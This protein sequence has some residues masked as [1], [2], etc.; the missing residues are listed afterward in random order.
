[1]GGWRGGVGR[2][3][4]FLVP[5]GSLTQ[6]GTPSLL[7]ATRQLWDMRMPGACEQKIQAH[8]GPAYTVAWHPTRRNV[9]ASAGRDKVIRVW[10]VASSGGGG[11]EPWLASVQTIAPVARVLWRPG[12]PDQIASCS[13]V[14]DRQIQVWDI[15]HEFI[16]LLS[17]EVRAPALLLVPLASFILIVGFQFHCACVRARR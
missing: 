3:G 4:C 5:G 12:H 8:Q 11:R 15:R 14:H 16:P 13:L 6:H 1:V 9:L 17:F 2:G 7:H 10:D